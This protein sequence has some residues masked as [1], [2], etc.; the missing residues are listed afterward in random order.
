[1]FPYSYIPRFDKNKE[2]LKIGDEIKNL[3]TGE[4]YTVVFSWDILAFGIID[5][6]EEFE[7]MS[8]WTEQ[9]WEKVK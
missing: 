9:D 6:N 5:E 7:F 8:E 4:V 2:L 1:M 3:Q